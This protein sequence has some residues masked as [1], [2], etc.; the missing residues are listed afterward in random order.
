VTGFTLTTVNEVLQFAR[1]EQ[2]NRTIVQPVDGSIVGLTVEKHGWVNYLGL[3]LYGQTLTPEELVLINQEAV[4][5][6]ELEM[7]QA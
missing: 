6:E 1:T 2:N 3:R 5:K 4:E 7:E